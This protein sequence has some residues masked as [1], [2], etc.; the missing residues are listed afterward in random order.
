[1]SSEEGTLV[2]IVIVSHGDMAEGLLDAARMIVG[3]QEGIV[4]V[5]LREMD[6]VEGLME[7]VAAAIE[8][9][10]SSDGVLVLVDLFGA[11]PFNASARLAME[12]D[13]KIEVIAGVSLPMLVELAVQRDGESL[14]RL[15]NIAREAGTSG[16]RTLSETLGG[17]AAS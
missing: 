14:E 7:R 16:I 4:T 12:G 6:A 1:M 15:V 17:K 9:V 5:S 8:K 10:D 3:E 11:S 2:G 13:S